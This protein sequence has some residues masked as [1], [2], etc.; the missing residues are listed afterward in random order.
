MLSVGPREPSLDETMVAISRDEV[1]GGLWV[2]PS[3][4]GFG[5]IG[6]VVARGWRGRGVGSALMASVV[7][8][9]RERGLHKLTLSVFPHNDAAMALYRKYGF[10]VEGHHPKQ[11][12]RASGELWDLVDM[13][14]LLTTE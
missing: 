10:V 2:I 9:A 5:E 4:F 8:W 13:G 1:I 12:R 14:L 6:M 11:I 3:P 7:D